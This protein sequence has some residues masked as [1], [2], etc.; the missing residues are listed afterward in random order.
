MNAC[1]GYLCRSYRAC[2]N[3]EGENNCLGLMDITVKRNA[4][5]KQIDSFSIKVVIEKV[6][7]YPIHSLSVSVRHGSKVREIT[8][9]RFVKLTVI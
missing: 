1:F 8:W 4:Y 6:S 9:K 5:G 2:K 3:I 7:P